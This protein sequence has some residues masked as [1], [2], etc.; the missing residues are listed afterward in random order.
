[1]RGTSQAFQAAVVQSH[2][3]ICLVNVLQDNKVV[4]QLA[5]HSGSVTADRT[6][7]QMR[8]FDVEVSDP[9]GILTP[10]GISALLAPFGTRLQLSRGVRIE[11]VQTLVAFYDTANS[12]NVVTPF[13]QMNGVVGDPNSGALSLGHL[14]PAT[15]LYPSTTVYPH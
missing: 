7:A 4:A 1:M 15:S 11:N 5:V 2:T 9:D 13:G 3:A 10:D 12:W 8:S 14:Y 6:A